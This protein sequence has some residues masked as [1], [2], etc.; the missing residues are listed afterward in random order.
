MIFDP[1]TRALYADDGSFLKTVDCP[2]A[3]RPENL[4][5]LLND[6]PNRYCNTCKKTIYCLDGLTDNDVKLNIF[7]DDSK[8][9]FSTQKGNNIVFLQPI[10]ISRKNYH[11]LPTVQTARSLEIMADMQANGHKLIFKNVGEASN[12]GSKKYVVYQHKLTGKIWWSGDY[13]NEYPYNLIDKTEAGEWQIIRDWFFVRP[14]QPFPLAAY[15]IPKSII[16][17]ARVFLE[18]VIEDIL[19]ISWN[20]GNAER[21]VSS[22]ATWTGVDFV[23]DEPLDLCIVG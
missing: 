15:I 8:C 2:L 5:K 18:D 3:L 9:V 4:L 12:F 17:G 10:G 21:I 1:I 23:I 6:S 7:E 20:Q 16:P 22:A 11:D 13:R 19:E 14:D